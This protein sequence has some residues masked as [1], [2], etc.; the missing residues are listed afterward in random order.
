ME[1]SSEQWNA[2]VV[3]AIAGVLAII[4]GLDREKRQRPA[5]LR[6]HMLV[7]MSCALLTIMSRIIYGSDSEARM[8]ANL[9][10]GI[11]FLGAGVVLQRKTSV[12]GLTTAASIWMVAIVGIVVGYELY[13]LAIGSTLLF[14]FVLSVIPRLESGK[15]GHTVKHTATDKHHHPE[16]APDP[17]AFF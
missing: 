5:G 8:T 13:I 1:Y 11:G 16:E 6:T 2:L 12:H 3:V 9:L 15:N 14:A 7:C 4:P 10:T 17:K